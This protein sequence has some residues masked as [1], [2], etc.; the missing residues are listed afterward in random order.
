MWGEV[1]VDLVLLAL[2]FA[3]IVRS[4]LRS[5]ATG[6][7]PMLSCTSERRRARMASER[8][9][10]PCAE[11][12]E[13]AR[14]VLDVSERTEPSLVLQTDGARSAAVPPASMEA[15]DGHP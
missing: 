15:H 13:G 7:A 8:T 5:K 11:S 10:A 1:L 3:F 12:V 6:R 9:P 4:G 2:A 14:S